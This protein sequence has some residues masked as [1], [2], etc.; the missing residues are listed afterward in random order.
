MN[1]SGMSSLDAAMSFAFALALV[2]NSFAAQV[3]CV[4]FSKNQPVVVESLPGDIWEAKIFIK[5]VVKNGDLTISSDHMILN[6]GAPCPFCAETIA[7]AP[8]LTVPIGSTDF[9]VSGPQGT[10]LKRT[11]PGGGVLLVEG[12]ACFR[13]KRARR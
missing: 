13:Q 6:K 10:T 5:A 7:I 8:K 12:Q 11:I 2:S 1:S 4:P 3:E 9:I